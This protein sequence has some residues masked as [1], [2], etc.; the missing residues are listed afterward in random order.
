MALPP[1]DER[2]LI[3]PVTHSET[4]PG[5]HSSSYSISEGDQLPA[6]PL[7][8]TSGVTFWPSPE[9]AVLLFEVYFS[10]LYNASLLFHKETFLSEYAANRIPDFVALSIF[11]LASMH[12]SYPSRS[13][14][15]EAKTLLASSVHHHRSLGWIPEMMRRI[16]RYLGYL[17]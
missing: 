12:V 2:N 15:R 4:D 6:Q 11:T 9:V 3:N 10:R 14:V 17:Y 16:L 5:G 13:P 8:T 1:G 7:L